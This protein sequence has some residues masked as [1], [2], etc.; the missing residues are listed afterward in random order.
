MTKI[1]TFIKPEGRKQY[2]GA[3][4]RGRKLKNRKFWTPLPF[5]TLLYPFEVPTTSPS[6]HTFSTIIP[7][8]PKTFGFDFN[9]FY[10]IHSVQIYFRFFFFFFLFKLKETS[11]LKSD[12]ISRSCYPNILGNEM[13][14]NIENSAYV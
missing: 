8:Y 4:Q 10:H 2:I 13:K 7:P 9:V 12:F 14:N 6:V 1:I 3:I 11:W 5:C